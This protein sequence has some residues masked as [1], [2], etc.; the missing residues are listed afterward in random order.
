M[1]F[2]GLANEILL[3]I[4]EYLDVITLF[5]SFL[6]LNDRFNRI[7]FDEHRRLFL[8]FNS[9]KKCDFDEFCEENLSLIINQIT[10]L[11]L[12]NDIETP[13]LPQI[14]FENGYPIH[15]FSGLCSLSMDF[16][17]SFQ[18]IN[19]ITLQTRELRHLTYLNI[20]FDNDSIQKR[21]SIIWLILYG[22][23]QV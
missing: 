7:I 13:N 21:I 8:N 15:R 18:F 20:K 11:H 4:F 17:L 16:I 14:L 2:E 23:Y 19:E 3:E 9:I 22:V 12:S 10:S 1:R 6:Q 5:R